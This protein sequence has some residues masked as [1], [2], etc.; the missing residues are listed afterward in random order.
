MHYIA[1]ALNEAINNVADY[2]VFQ[3]LLS[4]K[5]KFNPASGNLVQRTPKG[6][7]LRFKAFLKRLSNCLISPQESAEV[8]LTI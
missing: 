3:L 8:K 2:A 4:A 1:N 7:E 6:K 5:D